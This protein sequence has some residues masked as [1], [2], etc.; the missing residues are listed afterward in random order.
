M[1]GRKGVSGRRPRE[2]QSWSTGNYMWLSFVKAR[3]VRREVVREEAGE[4]RGLAVK[5]LELRTR[6]LRDP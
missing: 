5:G 2:K 4:K 6:G 1:K 3:S